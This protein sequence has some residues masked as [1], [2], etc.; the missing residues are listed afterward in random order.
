[1]Y[2]S[3]MVFKF[4]EGKVGSGGE[5]DARGSWTA[6]WC[7]GGNK[8]KELGRTQT[9]NQSRAAFNRAYVNLYL[10]FGLLTCD[11]SNIHSFPSLIA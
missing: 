2:L 9:P 7:P 6:D 3:S 10:Y 5:A 4:D 1:M 11:H 8:E